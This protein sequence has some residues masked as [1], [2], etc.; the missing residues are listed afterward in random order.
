MWTGDPPQEDLAKSGYRSERTVIFF[1]T[2]LC[3]CELQGYSLNVEISIFFPKNVA[4]LGVFPQ[5]LC[6]TRRPYF[7]FSVAKR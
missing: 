3:T 5:I 4:N 7:F 1:E 6:R 2:L